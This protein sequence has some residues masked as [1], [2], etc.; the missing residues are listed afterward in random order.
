MAS[1]HLM[2]IMSFRLRGRPAIIIEQSARPMQAE[3]NL[4]QPE[5][6]GPHAPGMAV[7]SHIPW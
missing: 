1:M 6:G 2:L 7:L 3:A 4:R 5:L